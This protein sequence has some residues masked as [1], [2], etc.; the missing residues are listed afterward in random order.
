MIIIPCKIDYLKLIKTI[1]IL[2]I[3]ALLPVLVLTRSCDFNIIINN[4][5][6]QKKLKYLISYL[7]NN[8]SIK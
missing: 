5:I 4:R 1:Y 3:I 7:K 6:T 8:L 2:K